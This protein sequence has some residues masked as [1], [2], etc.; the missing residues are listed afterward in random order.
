MER[1]EFLAVTGTVAV[2]AAMRN[3][4]FGMRNDT[5]D[6]ISHSAFT[7]SHPGSHSLRATNPASPG[8]AQDSQARSPRGR[9]EYEFSVFHQLQPRAQRTAHPA[10][11]P[12]ER[13]AGPRLPVVR[14]RTHQAQHDDQRRARLG[15]AG[16]SL[17][18]R[19]EGG[20][21]NEAAR[22]HR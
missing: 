9:A 10:H 6:S 17:A 8:R 13:N 21:A 2:A 12:C 1:R 5:D 7:E 16:G 11:D 19:G 15:G 3:A 18:A 22:A 4:E 20:P 14:S